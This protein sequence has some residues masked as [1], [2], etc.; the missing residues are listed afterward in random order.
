MLAYVDDN[1][2]NNNDPIEQEA[3]RQCVAREIEIK[4]LDRL[5]YF[6]GIKVAYFKE[7]SLFHN[8]NM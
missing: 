1:I 6:L 4:E 8:R 2:V 5:K 7:V 3:L